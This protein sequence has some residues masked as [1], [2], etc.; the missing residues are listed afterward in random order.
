MVD[1]I[2]RLGIFRAREVY[3]RDLAF[4]LTTLFGASLSGIKFGQTIFG[5]MQV[6]AGLE[7]SSL[8]APQ[9]R[10]PCSLLSQII[11]KALPGVLILPEFS[12]EKNS[13][14]REVSNQV[15][16]AVSISSTQSAA[17]RVSTSV[18]LPANLKTPVPKAPTSLAELDLFFSE[19]P[20]MPQVTSAKKIPETLAAPTMDLATAADL[21]RN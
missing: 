18:A 14:L 7:I 10:Y 21:F 16:R 15:V 5:S 4:S 17:V 9:A 13:D 2:L 11:G 8:T 6:E 12:G 19:T 1:Y 3:V 20:V